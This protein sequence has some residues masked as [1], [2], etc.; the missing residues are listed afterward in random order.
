MA[1]ISEIQEYARIRELDTNSESGGHH[2][3]PYYQAH[4]SL[5]QESKPPVRTPRQIKIPLS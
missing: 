5:K 4:Y 1:D 3:S 2:T